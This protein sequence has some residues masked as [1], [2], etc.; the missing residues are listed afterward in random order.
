MEGVVGRSAVSLEQESVGAG[1]LLQNC[2]HQRAPE[3]EAGPAR[4]FQPARFARLIAPPAVGVSGAEQKLPEESQINSFDRHSGFRP[5]LEAAVITRVRKDISREQAPKP[6]G[7]RVD[8]SATS[9]P[10]VVR[11]LKRPSWPASQGVCRLTASDDVRESPAARLCFGPE[12]KTVRADISL[13]DP[14]SRRFSRRD[15]V[16]GRDGAVYA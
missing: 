15:R 11:W 16:D 1:P 3:S 10:F 8:C 14:E 6:E 5:H 13:G 7:E 9:V 2:M 4:G 12:H